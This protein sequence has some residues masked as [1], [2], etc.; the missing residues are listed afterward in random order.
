[1]F[2][3]PDMN[4]LKGC[5][6]YL[7]TNPWIFLVASNPIFAIGAGFTA[8]TSYQR[9]AVFAGLSVYAWLCI[10]NFS[11]YIQSTGF[12][13]IAIVSTIFSSPIVYFDRLIYRKWTYEDRRAI[14][15]TAPIKAAENDSQKADTM[16]DGQDTFSSR[17]AFGQEVAGTVRGP[18][19]PFE[20]KGIP[21][22]SS[23]DPQWIPSPVI[24][25]LWRLAVI[26][27]CFFVNDY[28]VNV[29]MAL[30]HELML[31][32]RV[33]FFTRSGEVTRDD[34]VTRLVVGVSTWLSGYCLM[35]IFFGFPAL[36]SVWFKPNDVALW[37]PAFGS[38]LDAYTVRGFWGKFW[39]QNLQLNILGPARF[40]TYD[41]LRLPREGLIQ[42]YTLIFFV[43]FASGC[44]HTV[45]DIGASVALNQSGALR[46]FTTQ[47]LGIMLE[48]GVQEIYRCM[49]GGTK[50]ALWS[51]IVGYAWVLAF[52]SWSTAAWQY[53]AL[54]IAKKEEAGFRLDAF[55]SLGTPV[56]P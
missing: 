6:V 52:I 2:D 42:R 12:L 47:A 24:F 50:P 53:P 5:V 41:V 9:Y 34:V 30:D 27:S 13:S 20:A 11:I 46:F 18:G 38:L 21:P 54:L 29:R 15:G 45:S 40:I 19:T 1:M 26:V 23:T 56:N 17:F 4:N 16:A 7:V 28:V 48:D 44:F 35:Q 25:I 37:R 33:P 49:R 3:D 8:P 36:I 14:F 55:R 32:S 43:F 39:H 31:P 51:R 10:S 22:F